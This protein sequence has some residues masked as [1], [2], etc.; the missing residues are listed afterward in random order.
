[1]RLLVG[2]IL[3]AAGAPLTPARAQLLA[4]CSFTVPELAFGVADTLSTAA[5]DAST[6]IGINCSGVIAT[7]LRICLNLGI[8]DGGG[9]TT[10]RTLATTGGTLRYQLYRDAARTQV[11]GSTDGAAAGLPQE[12]TLPLGLGGSASTSVTLYGRL[13]GSQGG[14]PAGAYASRFAGA[15]VAFAYGSLSLGDCGGLL[16][17]GGT[18]RPSFS[19]SA[20]VVPDCTVA[21]EPLSFGQHGVLRDPVDASSRLTVAC[22]PATSYTVGLGSGGLAGAPPTARRMSRG[23]AGVTY[24][25]YRDAGRSRPWGD[26]AG[27]TVAGTGTG[28]AASLTVYGRIPP[29]PTPAP[30]FYSDT[31]AVTVSY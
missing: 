6:T 31:V 11:W 12:L 21:A 9:G 8:G 16:V 26:G 2:L 13:F 20:T 5:I 1:M 30:G 18:A 22:T 24:G 19:V 7:T 15:D 25:L 3:L 28:G 17:L 23:A 27:E 14:A 29:Q 4:S 10:D